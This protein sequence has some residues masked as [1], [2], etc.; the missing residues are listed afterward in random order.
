MVDLYIVR[1]GKE[2]DN[3]STYVDILLILQASLKHGQHRIYLQVHHQV[4]TQHR[5]Y[6]AAQA[7]Q[8]LSV[9][10]GRVSR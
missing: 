2:H 6:P 5:Y 9:I 10:P 7:Q 4:P 3:Q 8:R 1:I